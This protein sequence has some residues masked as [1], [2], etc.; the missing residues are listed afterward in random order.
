MSL[1]IRGRISI[2]R[3]WTLVS[4]SLDEI[5]NEVSRS[6]ALVERID[7]VRDQV[8]GW[9]DRV[10]DEEFKTLAGETLE[11]LDATEA[12]IRQTKLESSQ[13]VLNFPSKVDNQLVYLM[14]V[15]ESTPG[16]PAASSIERFDELRSEVDGIEGELDG[17]LTTQVPELEAMLVESGAPRI[18]TE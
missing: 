12:K 3:R 17:I 1:P 16:F 7:S 5:W 8:K 11:A 13:D 15:V 10:D 14:E 4:S 2:R 18:D 6:Y 9:Q